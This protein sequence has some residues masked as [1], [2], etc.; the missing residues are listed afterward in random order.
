MASAGSWPSAQNPITLP[1]NNLGPSP[2]TSGFQGGQ[3]TWGRDAQW[4]QEGHRSESDTSFPE[5]E[6]GA[7][8]KRRGG[9]ECS[10]GSLGHRGTDAPNG[11]DENSTPKVYLPLLLPQELDG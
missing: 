3:E 5:E 7:A 10:V 4:N 6:E 1:C 8:E 9:Q 2:Q 11:L